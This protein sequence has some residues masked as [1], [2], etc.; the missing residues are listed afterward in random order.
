M[1]PMSLCGKNFFHF[2]NKIA[3][4]EKFALKLQLKPLFR[5]IFIQ[6]L[7]FLQILC[8]KFNSF[9]LKYMPKKA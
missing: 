3:F 7:I 2:A 8:Q 1:F 4:C 5:R 6:T 9:R